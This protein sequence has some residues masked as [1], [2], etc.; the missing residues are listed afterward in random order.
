MEQGTISEPEVIE[1]APAVNGQYIG[2]EVH[3]IADPKTGAMS[4]NAPQNLIIALGL[5]EAAKAIIIQKQQEVVNK[6]RPPMILKPS[7]MDVNKLVRP[8]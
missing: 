1:E 6:S 5:I 8:S 3:I 7:A 2:G 4:I